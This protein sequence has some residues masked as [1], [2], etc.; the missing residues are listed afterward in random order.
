MSSPA[1]SVIIPAYKVTEFIAETLDSVR[2]QT[3]RDFETIV[4]NDGCPDTENLERVLE[5]YRREIVYLKQENQGLSGAR[6]TGIRAAQ[7]PLVA[8][9]DSDDLWEPEYLEI[10]TR[11]LAEHP[12]ADVVYPNALFFGPSTYEGKT[13]MDIFPSRG[14]VTLQS[15]LRRECQVFVSITG[16][17]ETLLRSGLFDPQLRSAEDLDMWLRLA[18]SGVRFVYHTRPLARYRCRENPTANLSNDPIWM[19]NSILKVYEKLRSSTVLNPDD[20][21]CLEDAI[22]RERATVDFF[23]GKKAL[24]AGNRREALEKFKQANAVLQRRKI[25]ATILGLRFAPQLLTWYVHRHYA[26]EYAF[27]H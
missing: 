18:A 16:R 24:W 10:Q 2:A 17:R 7:A 22:R 14:E 21:A 8:L 11:M 3:F 12:E 27:L 20:R 5:P 26:S 19:G 25:S 4:V 23:L 9:L 13:M 6:N 15:L 1:V